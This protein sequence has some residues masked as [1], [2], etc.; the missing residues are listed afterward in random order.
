[1]PAPTCRSARPPVC[2]A[3]RIPGRRRLAVLAAVAIL[4][5]ATPGG[6]GP[7]TYADALERA[8]LD[9]PDVRARGLA[10]E[11]ARAA[12]PAAGRLPD[13]ELSLAVEN[14]PVSG[15]MAGS[16]GRDEMTMLRVGVMQAV[17]SPARRRA[18]RSVAAADIGVADIQLEVAAREA[19]VAAAVAWTELHFAQRR[20]EALD[21]VLSSL[22]PL[23]EAA[24]SSVASGGDRPAGALS[25][26]RLRAALQDRRSAL[27]AAE[28]G[29][30]AEL[31][32]WTGEPD[33]WSEG[34]PPEAMLDEAGLRNGLERLPALRA[35]AAA[36][37][38]ADAETDLARAGRQ[39][40]WSFELAYGRRDPTY[41]DMLS[42]GARVRLPL[43]ADQRQNPVIAA[44]SAEA[45]RVRVE[46]EGAARSL[47]AALEAD[48][49][50]HRMHHEQWRRA[51]DVLLPAAR[52]R[53]GLETASYGAGRA[54]LGEVIEAFT[55][56]AET[57]LETL[58]REALVVRES[59]RIAL[60]Y[61]EDPQ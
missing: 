15:P 34:L 33:P 51:R 1:M 41:G 14:L 42:V 61:G 45:R 46:H 31:T 29:A 12:A 28:A 24:P 36:A 35:R 37:R 47:R 6:A 10:L 4:A 2:G 25:P 3:P 43:F 60:T 48:L 57:R 16:F 54:G 50:D 30:R 8:A 56:L 19:R 11:G 20:R 53:A 18:E 27:V 21:E 39:P 32:R 26:I 59:V 13:P 23:W 38:R 40:D 52:D 5:P 58:D 9:A 55:A 7:L 17:P 49:A 44:R 22:E